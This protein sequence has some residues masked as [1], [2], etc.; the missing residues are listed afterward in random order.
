MNPRSNWSLWLRWILA[1]AVGELI[2]LGS[3]FALGIGL[4]PGLSDSPGG[5]TCDTG[6]PGND[7]FRYR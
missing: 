4:L 3:T 1:N 6:R 5:C 2:G 7:G